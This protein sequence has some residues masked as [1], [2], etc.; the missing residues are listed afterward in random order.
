MGSAGV[1]VSSG[2]SAL[3]WNPANLARDS[4]NMFNIRLNTT[5]WDN[6][7]FVDAEAR[8][9]VIKNFDQLLDIFTNEIDALQTAFDGGLA[10]AAQVQR[11]FETVGVIGDLGAA[12]EGL[13]GDVGGASV[14]KLGN[15][16]LSF[17]LL[18]YLSASAPSS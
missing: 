1:A 8:G 14:V 17:R 15:F 3:Y 9:D 6:T 16:A 18:S 5:S 4:D 2:G 11:V 13:V 12:G 7:V 10:N